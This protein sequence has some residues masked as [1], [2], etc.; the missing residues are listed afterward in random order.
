MWRNL[1]PFHSIL[2]K[3]YVTQ[4]SE[5]SSSVTYNEIRQNF[6]NSVSMVYKKSQYLLS[7]GWLYSKYRYLKLDIF[8]IF[9]FQLLVRSFEGMDDLPTLLKILIKFLLTN[10]AIYFTVAKLSKTKIFLQLHHQF[11]THCEIF[12][13][14][15]KNHHALKEEPTVIPNLPNYLNVA[16]VKNSARDINL[17][18]QCTFY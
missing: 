14:R 18:S 7:K 13:T 3:L 4:S 16:T 12:F 5:I 10:L 15:Q 8:R 1:R 11:M 6:S 17:L 2:W 9:F